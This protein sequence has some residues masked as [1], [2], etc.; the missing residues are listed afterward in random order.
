MRSSFEIDSDGKLHVHRVVKSTQAPHPVRLTRQA[1]II[2]VQIFDKCSIDT[3]LTLVR[4]CHA[5][6]QPI[7]IYADDPA[8]T[9][10]R[11]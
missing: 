6:R 1:Q 5:I 9:R 8:L 3:L 7:H 11:H 4:Q 10:T 2:R